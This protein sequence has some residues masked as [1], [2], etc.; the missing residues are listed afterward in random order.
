MTTFEQV[1]AT[2]SNTAGQIIDAWGQVQVARLTAQAAPYESSYQMPVVS[3]G[4]S[5]TTMLLLGGGVLAVVA[6]LALKK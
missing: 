6:F 3:P 2:A 5:N 4:L 1:L